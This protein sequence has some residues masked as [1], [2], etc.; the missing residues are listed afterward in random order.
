M[1]TIEYASELAPMLDLSL[2]SDWIVAV[3]PEPS[4]IL[5][6][7]DLPE[8][9]LFAELLSGGNSERVVATRVAFLYYRGI[10][11][12]D[13]FPWRDNQISVRY[14]FD[15]GQYELSS[16]VDSTTVSAAEA[17]QNWLEDQY[18]AVEIYLDTHQVLTDLA[19]DIHGLGPAGVRNL[20]ETF[21]TLDAIRQ[22]DIEALEEVSYVNDEIATALQT[23]LE[24]VEAV[25]DDDPT[26]FEQELR[27][28]DDPL[29]VDLERGA[30]S[31]ELVPSGASGPTF[32]PDE[33]G[34][35]RP[36]HR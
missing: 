14:H 9:R 11:P 3:I 5:A 20:V 12:E 19:K 18:L 6:E 31:G 8:D 33:L 25:V 13:D 26:L 22:A 24:D 15:E 1:T 30:I 34:G 2:P 36:D 29:I 35:I 16:A 21:E 17:A 23:S 4:Q 10:D 27:T 28:V 32:S 7:S